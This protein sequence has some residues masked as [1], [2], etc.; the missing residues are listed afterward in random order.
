MKGMQS[1][2]TKCVNATLQ[3]NSMLMSSDVPADQ[4]TKSA[5]ICVDVTQ[6]LSQVSRELSI[7]RRSFTRS[8]VGPEYKPLCDSSRPITTNLFGDQLTEDIK[9]I[10][11]SKQIADRAFNN[12]S[13]FLSKGRGRG[14][15]RAPHHQYNNS[16]G[17]NSHG[18]NR[19]HNNN[20]KR[21]KFRGKRPYKK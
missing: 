13:P 12:R 9:Q 1:S 15:S 10:N 16:Y 8:H 5:Q 4:K 6:M 7:K 19:F 21:G 3:L 18:S 11:V 20:L 17:S 14:S 2:L